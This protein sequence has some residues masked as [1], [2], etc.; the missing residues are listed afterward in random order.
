MK[1]DLTSIYLS[2]MLPLTLGYMH[3]RKQKEG[4]GDLTPLYFLFFLMVVVA[5]QK[6]YALEHMYWRVRGFLGW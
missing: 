1:L 4:G 2:V 6:G 3:T 5:F